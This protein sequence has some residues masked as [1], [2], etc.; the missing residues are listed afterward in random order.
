[1]LKQETDEY[2]SRYVYPL[3][4]N[5]VSSTREGAKSGEREKST[6]GVQKRRRFSMV[7][8]VS[9]D[10]QANANYEHVLGGLGVFLFILETN[11]TIC[12]VQGRIR[13]ETGHGHRR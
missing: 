2:Q 4:V 1:M 3:V 8:A 11:V 13:N 7:G 9:D 5:A 12:F 10:E 6:L